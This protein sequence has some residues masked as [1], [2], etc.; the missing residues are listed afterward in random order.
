MNYEQFEQE[1]KFNLLNNNAK[2]LIYKLAEAPYRFISLLSPLNFKTKLEQAFYRSQEN[3]YYKYLSN[4]AINIFAEST[5]EIAENRVSV[6]KLIPNSDQQ[7]EILNAKFT[8]SFKDENTKSYYFIKQRKRDTYSANEAIKIWDK[9]LFDIE[10][11]KQKYQD[12]KI[13][14]ILWFTDSEFK[15]NQT[16]YN[17]GSNVENESQTNISAKYG[18]ELFQDFGLHE[19]WIEVELHLEKFKRQNYDDFLEF[20]DLDKDP[21]ALEALIELS[22]SAWE[23]LNSPMPVYMAIRSAIFNEADENS[24]L[25]KALKLRDIKENMVDEDE[26]KLAIMK[27]QNN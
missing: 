11:A 25:F 26:L 15:N 20:P 14:G 13:I 21:E 27:M 18:Y 6:S 24:N 4:F 17:S 16:Y 22:K 3:K 2:K 8:F 23:K 7:Y 5:Y 9:F 1:L 19:K 10:L 12:Y